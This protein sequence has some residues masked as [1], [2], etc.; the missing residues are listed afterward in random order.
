[1]MFDL[2]GG[3]CAGGG[4]GTEFGRAV[5]CEGEKFEGNLGFTG[6]CS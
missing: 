2:F 5:S 6:D 4:A 1:M 3:C